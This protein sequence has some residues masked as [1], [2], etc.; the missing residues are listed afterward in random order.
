LALLVTSTSAASAQADP[1]SVKHRNNCRLASQVVERAV[2]DPKRAW[3]HG[4]IRLCDDAGAKNA[5]H[6][7]SQGR[8]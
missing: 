5:F 3:A 8:P 2:S 1:D 4:Y 7:P 6:N